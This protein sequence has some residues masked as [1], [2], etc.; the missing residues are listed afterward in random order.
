MVEI[1]CPHCK[2]KIGVMTIKRV[3]KMVIYL[4]KNLDKLSELDKRKL[5]EDLE[6]MEKEQFETCDECKADIP[7]NSKFCPQCGIEFEPEAPDGAC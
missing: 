5:Q 7:V 6:K 3:R 1:T 2:Q 4:L